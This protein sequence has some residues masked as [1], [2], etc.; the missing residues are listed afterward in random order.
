MPVVRRRKPTQKKNMKLKAR[1][2]NP[3]TRKKARNEIATTIQR[4]YRGHRGRK[5][6]AARRQ[7][8]RDVEERKHSKLRND[9]AKRIQRVWDGYKT[10]KWFFK[11]TR[12]KYIRRIE[13]TWLTYKEG[14]IIRLIRLHRKAATTVQRIWRGHKTKRKVRA[15]MREH[16]RRRR[17]A[18][19]IQ[20]RMRVH[21]ARVYFRRDWIDLARMRHEV[22]LVGAEHVRQ[23]TELREDQMLIMG[24]F[25]RLGGCF[26]FVGQHTTWPCSA[27]H[28][29]GS[30][31][32]ETEPSECGFAAEPLHRY[33]KHATGLRYRAH[34]REEKAR[35]QAEAAT[36]QAAAEEEARAAA[37]LRS[38]TPAQRRRKLAVERAASPP[39]KRKRPTRAEK[40]AARAERAAAEQRQRA[41]EAARAPAFSY[42]KQLFM[43]LSMGN[44]TSRRPGFIGTARC[45]CWSCV[46]VPSLSAPCT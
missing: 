10:R 43:G 46:C 45:R 39:K 5:A 19:V 26:V 44:K 34:M 8:L 24:V 23:T 37:A 25:G 4:V 32:A 20:A 12:M 35:L 3:F 6:A 14:K 18:M 42:L 29:P 30:C 11:L 40:A 22:R 7:H 21:L 2:L 33:T 31:A 13:S 16:R 17:A 27:H 9:S 36:V 1:L 28:Q 38:M 15:A 41:A